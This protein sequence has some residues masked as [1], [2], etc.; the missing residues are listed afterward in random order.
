MTCTTFQH[1]SKN[2][3]APCLW[4][5]V[6][7]SHRYHTSTDEKK[8]T[9][10]VK[11]EPTFTVKCD[12]HK[13]N[14]II[15]QRSHENTH[16][17]VFAHQEAHTVP[18][19]RWCP[20]MVNLHKV[21]ATVASFWLLQTLH[22]PF[23]VLVMFSTALDCYINKQ[24]GADCCLKVNVVTGPA[25]KQHIKMKHTLLNHSSPNPPSFSSKTHVN[26]F[27]DAKGD[28]DV[29]TWNGTPLSTGCVC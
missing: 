8:A 19:R 20:Q 9:L 29:N 24:T 5:S 6:S 4:L 11:H 25:Q 26:T 3:K 13:T 27:N 10:A 1:K 28:T 7:V 21:V 15:A 14:E 16:T 23:W 18:R 22:H 12:T 2:S 17:H